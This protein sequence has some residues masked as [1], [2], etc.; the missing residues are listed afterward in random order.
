MP[1]NNSSEKRKS[2]FSMLSKM[3]IVT[4]GTSEWIHSFLSD[5]LH[6]SFTLCDYKGQRLRWNDNIVNNA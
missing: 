1:G 5:L 4:C 2:I 6:V 3:Q